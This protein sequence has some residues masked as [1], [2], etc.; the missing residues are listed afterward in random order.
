MKRV[1]KPEGRYNVTVTEVPRPE[2][3][4][5]EVL[6]ETEY[7]MISRGS[8]LW[9]RY[10]REEPV[11]HSRMGYSLGGTVAATGEEVQQFEVGD[12]VAAL[13][14][15][16]EFVTVEVVDSPHDPPV[17]ALPDSVDTEEG[18]FW[19][20][21]TSS[22][23]WIREVDPG[24]TDDVVI[25]GQGLVG[26][27][28]LQVGLAETDARFFALDALSLRCE[29]AETFGPHE[30]IDV[31]S[32]DP[33]EV[34]NEATDS[35]ADIVIEAVGGPAGVTVFDQAQSMVRRGGIIQVLGLYEDEPLPLDSSRIQGRRIVGGYRDPGKR[36]VASDRALELLASNAI[37][38]ETMITHRYSGTD[39]PEA[40]D[41]LHDHP[42]DA[43]GVILT[44]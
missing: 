1:E 21:A 19:P 17:V 9:A 22:V 41:F 7:T 15:H 27:G 5:T 18:T 34:V 28:C 36:P 24:P 14:P 35:G 4:S 31:S 39:A 33:V 40:F 2:C 12:R 30:V 44:W 23:M 38:V 8:E 32:V 10:S 43:L 26:S 16:A 13:A 25:Q 3:G 29:V 11:D 42:E 37:D 6:I 20:L